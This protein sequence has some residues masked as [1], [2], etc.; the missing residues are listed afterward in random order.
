MMI[1][2]SDWGAG[3]PPPPMI[4][5]SEGSWFIAFS[6]AIFVPYRTRGDAPSSVL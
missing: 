4:T 5:S 2:M 3:M 1:S 6:I